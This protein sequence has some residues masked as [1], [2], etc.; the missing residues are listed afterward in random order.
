MG[1]VT[2]PRDLRVTALPEVCDCPD[3]RAQ[4]NLPPPQVS[5]PLA[6]AVETIKEQ[7]IGKPAMER[8]GEA[9]SRGTTIAEAFELAK[10]VA[11]ETTSGPLH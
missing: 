11:L 9:L 5:A 10:L 8:L 2:W 6:A 4:A 7:G 1:Y 3:C